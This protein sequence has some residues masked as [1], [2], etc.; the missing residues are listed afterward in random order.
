[1]N[2]TTKYL[3]ILATSLQ[4]S[5]YII[6]K[7]PIYHDQTF[8]NMFDQM[9]KSMEHMQEMFAQSSQNSL[10][11]GVQISVEQKEKSAMIIAKGLETDSVDATV[12]DE[13]NNLAVKTDQGLINIDSQ[14][15][16]VSIN[17][18]HKQEQEVTNKDG[19]VEKVTTS[20]AQQSFNMSL[21]H[22]LD[23]NTEQLKLDYDQESKTL[24]IEIPFVLP[25]DPA[26]GRK[27]VAVN[28]KQTPGK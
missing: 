21:E 24:T 8:A 3:L 12:N 10:N 14:D 16:F 11:G 13:G 7:Q 26:K 5:F 27:Q 1:M 9:Q 28:I 25:Q 15:N 2:T 23:L 18:Q 6:A 17:W 22:P 19:K 4:T 20:F